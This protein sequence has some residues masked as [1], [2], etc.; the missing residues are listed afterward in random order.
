MIIWPEGNPE[1]S[2][3]TYMLQ[4][5]A[6]AASAS[7]RF[8]NFCLGDSTRGTRESAA[9]RASESA[10]AG[11]HGRPM[12][13]SAHLAISLYMDCSSACRLHNRNGD[14]GLN[15][16]PPFEFR[17]STAQPASLRMNAVSYV[18]PSCYDVSTE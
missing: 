8:L 16:L 2:R 9:A 12:P 7:T 18:V 4:T 6:V 5:K 11:A 1:K 10:S 3:C 14:F 17:V 13:Q 15:S